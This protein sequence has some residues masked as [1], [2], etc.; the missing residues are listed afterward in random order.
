MPFG[1]QV[2][3]AGTRF[4]LWAPAARQIDLELVVG[5]IRREL[6]M[7]SLP[8]GWFG[9]DQVEAPM[10]ARYSFRID[11]GRSVPDPASRYNPDDVHASSMVV[12]PLAFEWSD[13]DWAGRPWEEAII[14]ELHVGAFTKEGTFAAA[15]DR[16]D[17]LVQLG[18]TAVELM[19]IADFP[20]RR[21]WGYDGVLLFAPDASY[22]R[23]E[24]LKRLIDAAHA[25]GLMV[26]LDVVY[27]HFGPE[28]NYLHAYAP[29][30][31]TDRHPTPWGPAINFDGAE[32]RP[33][34]DFFVHNTLYWLEE[35]RFDGLRYDAVNRIR[36]D[37]TP[38]ILEEIAAT[39][40]A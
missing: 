20:G 38:H 8:E 29:T 7:T 28:G 25:L 33:V 30:F 35:Y 14:Y 10:G 19:P 11:G 37:S 12:D 18:V 1:A 26:F 6:A 4:R 34:R 21:G 15:A 27:N 17:Y 9:V 5:E 39:A 24:D 23:P 2:S 40:H 22:G 3:P 16:L 36:D 31:F 32:S 13:A